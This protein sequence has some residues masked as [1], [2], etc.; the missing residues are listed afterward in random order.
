[1][2]ELIK[3]WP[4]GGS[5]TVTYNGVGDGEAVFSSEQNTGIDRE[6][7][8]TFKGGG[9]EEVRKVTQV[10]LR[11]PF[12]LADGGVFRVKDDGRFGVLKEK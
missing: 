8:V 4:N 2:A 5:L 6:T 12:G 9:M 3:S 11:Q 7:E 1:M 10:G